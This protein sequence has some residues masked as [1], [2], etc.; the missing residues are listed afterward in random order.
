MEGGA[1]QATSVRTLE[2]IETEIKA[3]SQYVTASIIA[4]GN[5]LIE[6]KGQLEHGGWE[7]WLKDR[8]NFSQRTANNFMRIAR[9]IKTGSTLAELPYTKALA[10]LDVPTEQREQFAAGVDVDSKSAAALRKAIAD[11]KKAEEAK[12]AAERKAEEQSKEAQR[13]S[14]LCE[15]FSEKFAEVQHKL[16]AAESAEPV[17][18][19]DTI[20]PED[21]D[22][23]KRRA[24]DADKL[25]KRAQSAERYAEQQE[26]ALKQAQSAARRAQAE[27]VEQEADEANAP[28]S[29][30]KMGEAVRSFM[31]AMGAM[32]NMAS[33][34][35][36]LSAEKLAAYRPWLETMKAWVE[37]TEQAIAQKAAVE[38][39]VIVL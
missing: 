11:R 33:Y 24:A 35:V 1:L 13:A 19:H 22:D 5:A 38:A 9:E 29:P 37:G 21:Y 3:H 6:A 8:V 39:D 7:G 36:G 34:F 12:E 16:E 23:L 10:L 28:Y 30:A 25:E 27:Q 17:T 14:D 2:Q 18:I 32:P 20:Y 4:I 26:A 31:G 15:Q